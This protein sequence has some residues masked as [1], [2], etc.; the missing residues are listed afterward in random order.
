MHRHCEPSEAIQGQAANRNVDR[1]GGHG[2][3]AMTCP[4][5]GKAVF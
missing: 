5:S 3:L 1:R 4:D 2:R